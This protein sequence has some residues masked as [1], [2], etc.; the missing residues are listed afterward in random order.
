MRN[1]DNL[2][3]SIILTG[4]ESRLAAQTEQ[5]PVIPFRLRRFNDVFLFDI[6]PCL[7]EFR[8]SL[9]LATLNC[10]SRI[11]R[12]IE[13]FTVISTQNKSSLTNLKF[14][15]SL[16]CCKFEKV[17]ETCRFTAERLVG[18]RTNI[19]N[20]EIYSAS[21]LNSR[22]EGPRFYSMSYNL[23]LSTLHYVINFG[24]KCHP[25]LPR[26]SLIQVCCIPL[27]VDSADID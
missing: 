27:A 12:W 13:I 19:N 2:A 3:P 26:L 22:S 17:T 24:S 15:C 18:I 5:C 20:S 23:S 4:P 9:F 25:A 11:F 7:N 16:S 14:I 6:P 1:I 10:H 8:S 21:G